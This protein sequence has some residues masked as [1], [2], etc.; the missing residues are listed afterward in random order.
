MLPAWSAQT[1]WYHRHGIQSWSRMISIILWIIFLNLFLEK[2]QYYFAEMSKLSFTVRLLHNMNGDQLDYLPV[3]FKGFVHN[4]ELATS[5][6]G[7]GK[8]SSL[9]YSITT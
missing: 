3:H 4:V 1:D 8:I 9:I 5:S 7:S 2:V 6:S